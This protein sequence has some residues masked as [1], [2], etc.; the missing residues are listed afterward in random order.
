ML[1]ESDKNCDI[2]KS[3]ISNTIKGCDFRFNC[4]TWFDNK[5]TL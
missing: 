4:F 5:S 3:Q 1:V 2:H